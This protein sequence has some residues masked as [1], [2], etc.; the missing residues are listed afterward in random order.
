VPV[1][2]NLIYPPKAYFYMPY[3]APHLLQAHV[4]A[5]S[6]HRATVSDLNIDFYDTLWSDPRLP[7]RLNPACSMGTLLTA[8]LVTE[9]AYNAA[10]TLRDAAR[11]VAADEI[12]RA[13]R[14]LR[15][16]D[17]VVNDDM[18][19]ASQ[20]AGVAL[21]PSRHGQWSSIIEVLRTT[22]LGQTIAAA[23]GDGRFDAA[24]VVGLSVAYLGQLAPAL[25]LARLLK[26]RRRDSRIVVGGNAV[27]H[28]APELQVD[29]SLWCDVDYAVTHEG[30]HALVSLLDHLDGGPAPV[31]VWAMSRGRVRRRARVG[32]PPRA[33]A[34]PTFEHLDPRYP[35]PEPVLPLLTSK[36]C[37]WGRCTFCTHHE[38]YGQGYYRI[39]EDVFGAALDRL[40]AA[41]HTRFYFVDE[42]LPPRVLA[43][44]AQRFEAV[45]AAGGRPVRWMAEARLERSLSTPASAELLAKSGC[46]LLVNGIESGVQRVVD[47]MDKGI[48]VHAA[49]EHARQCS[50]NGVR[51]GWMFYVGHPGEAPDEA[52]ATFQFI[53]AN[54][55]ALDFA[56]V[57]AFSLE[58][59]SPIE[60]DPERFG[61]EE[62]VARGEPYQVTYSFTL[63]G[64]LHT[65]ETTRA[66]LRALHERYADLAPLFAACGDRALALFL[67][68]RSVEA[69]PPERGDGRFTFWSPSRGVSV[70]YDAWSQQMVLR[71]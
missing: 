22:Y 69:P 48:D 19:A 52:D 3:L 54:A 68:D 38:G 14:I 56:S 63:G 39:K 13:T 5:N 70:V 43:Q 35:T 4:E 51:V 8:E 16:A 67:P 41:G 53:R 1:E 40:T 66:R 33:H 30:E 25:L 44:L 15:L 59:G 27:T 26:E 29:R 36:G 42:A 50:A 61:I 20:Q 2:L 12:W 64:R 24:D 58:R 32:G 57:G 18:A 23:V 28:I 6:S 46:G 55:A 65:H 60:L 11:Y 37:Y 34:A 47:L 62:I 71:R 21:W 7:I 31:D 10:T 17:R 49:A 45:A 9:Q